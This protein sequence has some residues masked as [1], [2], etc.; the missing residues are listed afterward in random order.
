MRVT[1]RLALLVSLWYIVFALFIDIGFVQGAR[2]KKTRKPK[3][4]KRKQKGLTTSGDGSSVTIDGYQVDFIFNK[5]L[6]L[7]K[8]MMKKREHSSAVIIRK[9]F[10]H[11]EC[12]ELLETLNPVQTG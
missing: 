7:S 10:T 8:T 6:R 2:R 9:L 1:Y 3:K 11:E 4:E 5:T 12:V